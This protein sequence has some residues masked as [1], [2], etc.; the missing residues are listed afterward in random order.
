MGAFQLVVPTNF[1]EDF[2][3]CHELCVNGRQSRL[4]L[5]PI[6]ISKQ[7]TLAEISAHEQ[8]HFDTKE[9]LLIQ[10]IKAN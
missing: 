3:S 4:L 6:R 7:K 1:H 9:L 8:K 2:V 5:E 10:F